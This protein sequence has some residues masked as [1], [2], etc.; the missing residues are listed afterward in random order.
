MIATHFDD[1]I[2]AVRR[3]SGDIDQVHTW[4]RQLAGVLTGGGRLLACG[5]G[6]SAAEAQHLTAELVGRFADERRPL[7]A[8][9]LHADTSALTAVCNDYG[10][11]EI[12]ARGVRAHGRPGDVLVSLS[13]SGTS[14]N[15]LTAVKAAHEIG[16]TT[17]AFTG[18][19]PNPLAAT[20]TEAICVD[21]PSTA[22]VQEV[23]LLLVHALC[24]AVD[25]RIL[26]TVPS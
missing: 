20:C 9:A 4:A 6:G 3:A 15:V 22:T 14:Q 21:A 16:M 17:W 10:A 8:I 2:G 11:E 26:G 25:E 19:A 13:T 23:H 5:N 24:M 12:F 1:L 18:P 7:S